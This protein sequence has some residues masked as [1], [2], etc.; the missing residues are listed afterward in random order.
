MFNE[1][2][3]VKEPTKLQQEKMDKN[4]L[5]V[6]TG[7]GW[8]DYSEGKGEEAMARRDKNFFKMLKNI[9]KK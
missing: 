7:K 1:L 4:T 2:S 5:G 8:Y 3:D 9:H 6:K